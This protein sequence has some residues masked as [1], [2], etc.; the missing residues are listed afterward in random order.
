[1][2]KRCEP[3]WGSGEPL[4]IVDLAVPADVDR[5][6]GEVEGVRLFDVDDLRP[7]STKRCRR[8]FASAKVEGI[9]ERRSRP[10]VADTGGWRSSRFL[11]AAQAES[12][13]QRK[14]SARCATR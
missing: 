14:S 1:V 2:R 9:I 11:G 12:I 8:V 13:R 6:A 3:R 10:S 7:G 5:Q 4:V